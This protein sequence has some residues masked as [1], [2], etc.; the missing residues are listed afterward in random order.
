MHDAAFT[1]VAEHIGAPSSVLEFGSRNINGS[2]RDLAPDA[3][4]VGVDIAEGP[5]VDVVHDA[6]TVDLDATFQTVICTEVFEHTDDDHCLAICRNAWLHLEPGGKF[7][8]TMAGPGRPEH[9]AIDG[10]WR[11]HPGEF[12]RNVDAELLL[13]WMRAAGFVGVEIDIAGA[14]VRGCGV[15][16]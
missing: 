4:Y 14:D 13:G 11:L 7:I 12:Y 10:G 9:S 1:Y 16:P 6:A 5:G 15:R 3:R 2:C 8:T